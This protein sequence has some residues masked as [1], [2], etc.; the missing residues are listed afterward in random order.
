MCNFSLVKYSKNHLWFSSVNSHCMNHVR[1]SFTHPCPKHCPNRCWRM[2][3]SDDDECSRLNSCT[4]FCHNNI[5]SFT[6]SCPPGMFLTTDGK[7]CNGNAPRPM[8]HTQRSMPHAPCPTPHAPCPT[9]HAPRPMPR[10]TPLCAL[11]TAPR[12]RLESQVWR[13]RCK[14]VLLK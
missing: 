10:F 12:D 14:V 9:P 3:L 13:F 1:K 6:C 11:H 5:G 2:C 7:T 8:P 4:H